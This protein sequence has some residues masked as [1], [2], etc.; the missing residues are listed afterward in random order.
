MENFADDRQALEELRAKA[1]ALQQ[2][3]LS[4]AFRA[5]ALHRLATER[6]GPG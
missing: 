6:A 3:R 2:V 1:A 5:W 4:D